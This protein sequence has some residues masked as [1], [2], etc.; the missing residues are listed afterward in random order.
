MLIVAAVLVYSG[1]NP[2]SDQIFLTPGEIE[3][4]GVDDLKMVNPRLS[5]VDGK[6]RPYTVTAEYAE[7]QK[8]RPDLVTLKNIEADVTLEN[9]QWIS[10]N[11]ANGL[12]DGNGRTLTLDGG[13]NAYSDSGYE[14][15]TAS[16]MV[17]FEHGVIKGD[18]PVEAHGPLGT[19]NANGF[20]VLRDLQQ[21]HFLGS[22]K[23]HY[24]PQSR[25]PGAA[26]DFEPVKEEEKQE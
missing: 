5:G 18:Q 1:F 21:V 19:I 20:E 8:G 3:S 22:V 26:D 6:Q 2:N 7:Q 10:I 25:A 16:A 4:V 9:K 12:L 24:T 15:H 23:T 13:I 17:D 11:A 14:I